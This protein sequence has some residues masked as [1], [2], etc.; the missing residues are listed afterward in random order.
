MKK[1]K[2]STF[3]ANEIISIFEEHA[4][5]ERA[6]AMS[7]YMRGLFPFYGLKK[8]DRVEL[9]KPF[10]KQSAVIDFAAAEKIISRP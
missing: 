5:A 2:A 6:K 4:D 3:T 10:M 1:P 7:D 8:D 9:W